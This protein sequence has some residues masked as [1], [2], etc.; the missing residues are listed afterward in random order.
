MNR[1][2][3][4]IDVG[5]TEIKYAVMDDD[6]DFCEKGRVKTPGT[7][8]KEYLNTLVGIYETYAG[9]VEGIAMSVPGIIDVDKGIC[10][11]GGALGY[12]H[13]TP[14][15]S[16]MEE[17]CR[18]PVSIENDAKCAALAEAWKGSLA[19][20]ADGIVLV[21]GTGIGGGIIHN[22]KLYKGQHLMAGEF[23]FIQIGDPWKNRM[24]TTWGMLGGIRRLCRQAQEAAGED[25]NPKGSEEHL[26]P[27]MDGRKIFELANGGDKE[28]L[29]VVDRYAMCL[30]Q[31]IFN[32]Q[33]VY[34]PERFAVG[35]GISSQ[36][37]LFECISKNLDRLCNTFAF[38][39]PKPLVVP[40]R[41][42][43]DANLIGALKNYTT[44]YPQKVNH[45]R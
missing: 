34:D 43:N 25:E 1:K 28:I 27:Q 23:S 8:L 32:L 30:A 7:G 40:C 15:V 3:L 41:F 21:L 14:L 19:D 2:Y 11:T 20:C 4:V 29:Q 37:L 24:E 22:G 16:L 33:V 35:G 6:L 36:P 26:I 5:G 12:I 39:I 18:V 44:V 10:L 17:R 45:D 9:S 31:G 13:N 38:D 42:H